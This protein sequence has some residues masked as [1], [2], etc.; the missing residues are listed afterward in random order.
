MSVA[1]HIN[2]LRIKRRNNVRFQCCSRRLAAK[3][4]SAFF[5]HFFMKH[6]Q[7]GTVFYADKTRRMFGERNS[8]RVVFRKRY[9]LI[10][11]DGKIYIASAAFHIAELKDC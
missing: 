10:S 5:A 1:F 4:E 9:N 8:D 2:L 11:V 3:K 6:F 7:K